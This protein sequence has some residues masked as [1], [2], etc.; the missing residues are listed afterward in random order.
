MNIKVYYPSGNILHLSG[1]W[2]GPGNVGGNCI[3]L[4]LVDKP[5]LLPSGSTIPA[6]SAF[7]GDIRGLY[8]DEVTDQI[9][10]HPRENIEGMNKWAVDWLDEHPEWPAVLEL[11]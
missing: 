7:I 10:Y 6:G 2:K 1:E 5:S 9:L 4:I 3:I 8:T 11:I